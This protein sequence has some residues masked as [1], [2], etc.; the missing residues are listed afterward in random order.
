MQP[1]DVEQTYA[2]VSKSKRVLGYNPQVD[3]RDGIAEFV[4]WYKKTDNR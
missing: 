3:F 1:G 4:K 2:D